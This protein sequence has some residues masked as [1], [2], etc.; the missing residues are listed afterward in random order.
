VAIVAP[1]GYGKSTLLG[2]LTG[3]LPNGAYVRL[4]ETDDDPTVLLA[5]LVDAVETVRP[6]PE[7]F[8][9]AIATPAELTGFRAPARFTQALGDG[10]APLS[11][12]LDDLHLISDRTALDWLAWI[13]ERLPAGIRVV[14][15][16]RRETALPLGRVIASGQLL[17][18]GPRDLALDAQETEQLAELA[19]VVLT[20][21]RSSAL[22][23]RTEGWPL[24]TRL[25]LRSDSPTDGTSA[26]L[27]EADITRYLRSELFDRMDPET[28]D[29]VVRS[30]V[31]DELSGPLCD[32]ALGT[33][34]SLQR[35]RRLE[36]ENQL[37]LPQD[38]GRTSYRY[39]S[40]YREFLLGELDALPGERARVAARAAEHLAT[41]G[42]VR[43]AARYAELTGDLDHLAAHMERFTV[44]L[45][46]AGNLATAR[47]WL[48]RFDHDG[49][50]ERYATV[51]VLGAW[52]DALNGNWIGALRWL[53]AAERTT[54]RRPPFDGSADH[55]GW[56][57]S[58]RAN[59]MPHGR[60]VHAADVATALERLHPA[61]PMVPGVRI[62]AV[63]REIL[64]GRYEAAD[65]E[66][67]ATEAHQRAVGAIP[68]LVTVL[69]LR[70]VTALAR[71]DTVA[72]RTHVSAGVEMMEAAG[73][74]DYASSMPLFGVAARVAAADGDSAAAAGHLAH[75][76]RLRPS[77]NQ[78]LPFFG[79]LARIQAV[80][81]SIALR[82][83]AL[84]RT[85]LAEA[86]EILELRPD[87]GTL[88][89]EV[90]QLR[91][92]VASLRTAQ[93][94]PWTLTAAELRLLAYLPTHLTF[95]EIAQR[96]F[97]SPHT[98]KTQ[99]MSIYSKLEVSSRREAIE[100]AVEVNLLDASVLH[101]ADGAALI[102]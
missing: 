60:A 49:I 85:L 55:T 29:W 68:G 69:A 40:L 57:A 4:D 2:Q 17:L 38:A 10:A 97:L 65:V 83:P 71:R 80:R 28:R 81:A 92:V 23:A 41:A 95:R 21:A 35:L 101:Q 51:A 75:V 42:H 64:A 99:A 56:V 31:L 78:A 94:G 76:N 70:A 27:G 58:I 62:Q 59:L 26:R 73:L 91:P 86:E 32:E 48:A 100:R 16:S 3:R 6:L 79:L 9:R 37:L 46:Y 22:V 47:E 67:R 5:D 19:G 7:G 39:H 61:S 89:V 43:E 45:Y 34:G 88:A 11:L 1:A 12:L 82:E 63:A 8:R 102:A 52:A 98:I 36:A 54:D 50:R 30:S 14:L 44:R 18:L 87:M 15:S 93:P 33:T 66:A 84:A 72:A 25:L 13:L 24:A 20:P 74:G 77:M 90:E 53:S 96:M